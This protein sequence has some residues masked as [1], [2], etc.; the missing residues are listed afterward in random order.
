M[1]V[2]PKGQVVI[3]KVFRDE[4][5]INPGDELIFSEDNNRT[6]IEKVK[7]NPIEVFEKISNSKNIKKFKLNVHEIEEEYEERWRKVKNVLR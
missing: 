5:N 6:V 2:G 3:P 4:Y 1:K 7:K